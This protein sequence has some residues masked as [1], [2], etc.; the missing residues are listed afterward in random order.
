M[1][2]HFDDRDIYMYK[3]FTH[4]KS[5]G[6]R[7]HGFAVTRALEAYLAKECKG[8]PSY[9]AWNNFSSLKS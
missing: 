4:V 7:P 5:R 8:I 6:Q 3:G 2:L 1:V 9:V